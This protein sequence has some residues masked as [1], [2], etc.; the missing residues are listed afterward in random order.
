MS[1]ISNEIKDSA[2]GEVTSCEIDNV[3]RA[4]IDLSARTP[5]LFIYSSA[6]FWLLV[7]TVLGVVVS[8]KVHWPE[9][10]NGFAWLTYGRVV[11]AQNVAMVYGWAS[12]AG[13]GTAVWV[14][15]RIC[16]VTLPKPG[17]LIIGATLWNIAVA[18]G[19][20]GILRGGGRGFEFLEMPSKATFLL[21]VSYNLLAVWGFVIFLKRRSGH[22]FISA[23]YF[24]TAFLVFPWLLAVANVLVGQGGVSGVMQAV[25]GAWFAQNLIAFWFTALALGT[26]Y[27]LIPKVTGKA[28]HSY[29][30][31]LFGFWSFVI[32][33]GWSGMQR[34]S[35]G[36]IPAWMVTVGV[37]ASIL[38]LIPVATVIAN[39][40]LTL[41][42]GYGVVYSSP[43]IRFVAYGVIAYLAASVVFVFGS[44]RTVSAVT[45]LT[46]FS[47][48]ESQLFIYAFFSM[49]MFGA[50]YFIT[51]RLVGLEWL[52]PKFIRIHFWGS[53]YGIAMGII[54]L[55]AGGFAQGTAQSVIRVTDPASVHSDFILS[56]LAMLPWLRGRSLAQILIC[57]GNLTFAVHFVLM[58]FR[59]GRPAGQPTLFAPMTKGVKP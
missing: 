28:I 16:R 4:L 14:L 39:F 54:M 50:I 13:I 38:L 2:N 53:G 25:V 19:I 3:E 34:L 23:W 22:V 6:V 35:G 51:P 59:L 12:L 45:E 40:V 41:K 36:P 56:V 48:A 18:I 15:A 37:V 1:V 8:L 7:Q 58:L 24:I 21:F 30:L 17:L 43:T 9:F 27:Y 20:G 55:I 26:C 52:S 57:V 42:S 31:A 33:A 29:H 44:F 5:V 32:L 47:V 46:W 49:V 11:P 10:L